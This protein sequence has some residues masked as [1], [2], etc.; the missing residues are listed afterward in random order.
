MMS[1]LRPDPLPR[2]HVHMCGD[3]FISAVA[4]FS[5]SPRISE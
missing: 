4:F 2:A 1:G 3:D 5:G